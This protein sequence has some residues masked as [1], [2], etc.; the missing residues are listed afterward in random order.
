MLVALKRSGEPGSEQRLLR[1][2]VVPFFAIVLFAPLASDYGIAKFFRLSIPLFDRAGHID[3]VLVP[4]E[5]KKVRELF[6]QAGV[7]PWDP[8]NTLGIELLGCIPFDDA[9]GNPVLRSEHPAFLPLQPAWNFYPLVSRRDRIRKYFERFAARTQASG[10]LLI[11]DEG[12][13][14]GHPKWLAKFPSISHRSGRTFTNE[15]GRLVWMEYV[16]AQGAPTRSNKSAPP[17]G[18]SPSPSRLWTPK[19]FPTSR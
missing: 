17:T 12:Y 10:W 7:K 13:P 3:S 15:Y 6:E 4:K 5:T 19:R 1:A 16:G 9:N 8:I 11:P 2:M 18:A 14:N